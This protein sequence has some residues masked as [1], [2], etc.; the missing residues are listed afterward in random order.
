MRVLVTG[1]TGFVGGALLQGLTAA[2]GFD[3]RAAVR[4][5]SG[6]LPG[7]VRR[8]AVGEVAA[9]TVW[10]PALTGADVV[11]HLAARVHV[12]HERAA[13]P[14]AEFRGVN[15]AGTLN[16]ARQAAAAGLRRF[17]F[18]SSIKVNGEGTARDKPFGAEDKPAP[19]DAYGISKYEAELGLRAIA[20]ATGIEVVVIRPPLLYGPNVKGNFLRLLHWIHR[21]VPLPFANADNRRS[22]LNVENLVDF[23]VRCIEHPAVAGETLLVSDDEDFSTGDLVRHLAAGMG[24]KPRLFPLPLSLNHAVFKVMGRNDLWQR[25]FGSLQIN[26]DKAKNVLGWRPPVGAVEGLEGVGRWYVEKQ[27]QA[28]QQR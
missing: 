24:R 28:E 18:V 20:A 21:G 12:M 13:D 10:E 6:F 26:S 8:I 25:T 22:L 11:V 15:V 5:T 7:S 14:L 17:I 2:G 16:L 4:R 1:P 9:D 19:I 3:V 23:V 27:E